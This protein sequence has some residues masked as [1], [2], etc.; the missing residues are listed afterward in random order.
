MHVCSAHPR[1]CWQI[2]T[3]RCSLFP[4]SP[5][6]LRFRFG[7]SSF[8]SPLTFSSWSLHL[9][10]SSPVSPS[11]LLSFSVL[12]SQEMKQTVENGLWRNVWLSDGE[13]KKRRDGAVSTFPCYLHCC[14]WPQR[15]ED[16]SLI[17]SGPVKNLTEILNKNTKGSYMQSWIVIFLWVWQKCLLATVAWGWMLLSW[18]FSHSS[19]LTE[20]PAHSTIRLTSALHI[21]STLPVPTLIPLPLAQI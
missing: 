14:T 21:S 18:F 17:T 13:K 11:L 15:K 12:V 16:Q 8:S 10:R 6:F 20:S 5:L 4:R 9:T 7:P 19:S 2:T 1:Q 3:W